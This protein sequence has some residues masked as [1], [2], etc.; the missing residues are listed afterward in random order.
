MF[1]TNQWLSVVLG[2][3]LWAS[4]HHHHFALANE[5]AVGILKTMA[6]TESPAP[7]P[8]PSEFPTDLPTGTA[9]PTI[10]PSAAPTESPEPSPSRKCNIFSSHRI[11]LI[12]VSSD[13]AMFLTFKLMLPLQQ[14]N[15]PQTLPLSRL[16][17]VRL[18][19]C[20]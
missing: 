1:R 13:S 17:Q 4:N 6:P 9:K 15:S 8:S 10:S 19:L 12:D 20:R 3:A 14:V 7:S 11:L 18:H 16:L 2:A 5:N